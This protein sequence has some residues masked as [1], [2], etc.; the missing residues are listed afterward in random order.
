MAMHSNNRKTVG[1]P[2]SPH[3]RHLVN[4]RLTLNILI[5][6]AASH[7]HLTAHHLVKPQLDAINPDLV[8]TYDRSIAAAS[9]AY[10]SGFISLVFGR[11]KKY[12]RNLHRPGNPFYHH[13]FL[14]RHG[15]T[16][17]QDA[18]AAIV[19]RCIEKGVPTRWWRHEFMLVK[20]LLKIR[21]IESSHTSQLQRL[22]KEAC[23]EIVGT[24]LDLMSATITDNPAWGTV[25][26]PGT[27]KGKLIL[28]AMVGWGGV[29]RTNRDFNEEGDREDLQVV[30]KAI[31]WPL[32]LHEL[33]KGS[34]EL[35]CLHGMADLPPEEFDVVMDQTEHLEYEVPMIQIGPEFYQRFLQVTPRDASLA[36]CVM[37]VARMEPIELEE[38]CFDMMEMP[39]AA[40]QVLVEKLATDEQE[41]QIQ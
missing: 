3:L 41:D 4:K 12:W 13:R 1:D 22:A 35:I 21:A 10:W 38:F 5:Q 9:L 29:D 40:T 33:V 20:E 11:S 16:I 25:R 36:D 24:P 31:I 32:L 15:R 6:G 26:E 8:A 39:E 23:Y 28:K 30:A 19:Q 17:A 27:W 34:M 37:H 7:A 2:L 18:Q 14:R